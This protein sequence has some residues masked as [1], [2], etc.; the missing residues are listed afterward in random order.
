[1]EGNYIES[2]MVKG[3]SEVKYSYSFE[4]DTKNSVEYIFNV[5]K[6]TLWKVDNIT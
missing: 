6:V 3:I 4:E 5:G 2:E 1:M